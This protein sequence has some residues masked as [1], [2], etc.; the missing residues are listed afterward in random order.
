MKKIKIGLIHAT[1]NSVAPIFESFSHHK[2]EIELV[3]FMDEGLIY[4]LNETNI[5]STRMIMRLADL[6]GRAV[7]SDVDAILFTCS[8]FTPFVSKIADLISIPVLS[9]DISML[10]KAVLE[11]DFI[12]VIA[13]INAAG[14]T[15]EK[16]IQEIARKQKKEVKVRVQIINNA[17]NAIQ[18]GDSARHDKLIREAINLIDESEAIVLAQYSMAP[19][20]T[21]I[22]TEFKNVLTGPAVST[23]TIIKLAK[24]RSE[25]I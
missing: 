13:T 3:N 24:K 8:S 14:P 19:A 21:N 17:F 12:N 7:E 5:V 2:E 22:S 15:T 4:E 20:I 23:E 9:S 16:M 11:N 18:N 6:A 1:M 25:N 10:E